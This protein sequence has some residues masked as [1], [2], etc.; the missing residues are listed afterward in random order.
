MTSASTAFHQRFIFLLVL[1]V[2]TSITLGACST[3]S[4]EEAQ[5]QSRRIACEQDPHCLHP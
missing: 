2:L 4:A 5:K 1:A 3:S